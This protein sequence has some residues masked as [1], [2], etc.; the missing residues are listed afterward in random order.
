MLRSAPMARFGRRY[1]RLDGGRGI[2]TRSAFWRA[3]ARWL[4]DERT[5]ELSGGSRRIP[6]EE[7]AVKLVSVAGEL[8]AA[9]NYWDS[10]QQRKGGRHLWSVGRKQQGG[11]RRADMAQVHLSIDGAPFMLLY[12]GENASELVE[13]LNEAG[14]RVER[15]I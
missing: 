15:D 12:Q 10:A 5:L 3:P 4:H 1:G 11:L 6:Y 7:C 9:G 8:A 13:E 14:V 2:E